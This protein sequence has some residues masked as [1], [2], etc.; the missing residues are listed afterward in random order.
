M[1]GFAE[2]IELHRLFGT[3]DYIARVA[4]ADTPSL[5]GVP[6]RPSTHHPRHLPSV[7]ALRD[8]T[9]KSLRPMTGT[10]RLG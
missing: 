1:T 6:D 2:V 9:L 4:T 7:L 10:A 8:E 3:H 5:R